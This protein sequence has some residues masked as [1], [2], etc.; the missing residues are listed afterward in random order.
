[1]TG[2][3]HTSPAISSEVLAGAIQAATEEVLATMLALE[4]KAGQWTLE[5]NT[6][7]LS[8]GV[9]GLIGLAGRWAGTG[10]LSCSAT[11]ACKLSALLL[12][13][14]PEAEKGGVD[15]EVLDAMAEITNM[16]IGNV[17]N[18]VEEQLGPMG[19]SIPTVIYGRNFTTRSVSEGDWTVVRFGCGDEDLEVRVRLVPGREPHPVRHGFPPPQ[20]V[21]V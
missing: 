2:E 7:G 15:G 14:E 5:R 4:A 3:N 13:A 10:M 20:A 1:M 19:L 8:D 17:K 21:P 12:M 11:L 6:S 18:I 9:V 16:I